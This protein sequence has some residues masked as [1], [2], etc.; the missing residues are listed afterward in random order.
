MFKLST[1]I[2]KSTYFQVFDD[3][4]KTY[5]ESEDFNPS[6]KNTVYFIRRTLLIKEES[7]HVTE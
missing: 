6:G 2:V 3:V 4:M 7:S 1:L 5:E